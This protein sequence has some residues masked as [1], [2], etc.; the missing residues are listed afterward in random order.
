MTSDNTR[1]RKWSGIKPLAPATRPSAFAQSLT[2][3]SVALR[4]IAEQRI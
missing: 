1:Y 2:P 4:A 3:N